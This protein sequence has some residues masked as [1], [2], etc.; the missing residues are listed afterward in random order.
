MDSLPPSGE[1]SASAL[2][3]GL[4]RARIE[5]ALVAPANAVLIG[6]TGIAAVSCLVAESRGMLNP[7]TWMVAAGAGAAVL[8]GK[9]VL[10]LRDKANDDGLWRE[11]LAR[12]FGETMRDDLEVTRQARTA[13]EYRVRLAMAEARAPRAA[14]RALRPLLPRVDAWLERIVALARQVAVLRA[15]SRFHVA[16]GARSRERLNAVGAAAG[17]GL[18]AQVTAAEGFGRM[19]D[20]GLLRLENAVAAFGAS[21]S[22]LVQDLARAQ[23]LEGTAVTDARIGAAIT[24]LEGDARALEPPAPPPPP[25]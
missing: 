20:E 6:L 11:V 4:V 25:A 12:G 10:D 8:V 18:Q 17:A 23:G 21:C 22:T 24:A 16:M 14:R 9:V 13:I 3:G 7:G 5:A 19:A 1:T 15:D 2:R